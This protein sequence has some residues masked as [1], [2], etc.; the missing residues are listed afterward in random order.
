MLSVLL[1]CTL[2]GLIQ[3]ASSKSFKCSKVDENVNKYG[4]AQAG[5]FRKNNL[6]E[7]PKLVEDSN[8]YCE[9]AKDADKT[10]N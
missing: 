8:K 7:H 9:K 5:A 6:Y 10:L 3:L 1:F 2:V 4:S